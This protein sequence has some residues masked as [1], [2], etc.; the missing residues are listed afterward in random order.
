MKKII[1]IAVIAT[2]AV[3]NFT[4]VASKSGNASLKSLTSL[5]KANACDET[6]SK[7]IGSTKQ[8]KG[9]IC[10]ESKIDNITVTCPIC[11]LRFSTTQN[12]TYTYYNLYNYVY[13]YNAPNC[14]DWVWTNT[15]VITTNISCGGE[16]K[17][18][19]CDFVI[20]EE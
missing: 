7:P 6:P 15:Q 10:T 14:Y 1:I 20:R 11:R 16:I 19:D 18:P 9:P 2:V 8:E 12:C 13:A 4:L 3:L 17:C 5:A